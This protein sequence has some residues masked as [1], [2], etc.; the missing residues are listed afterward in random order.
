MELIAK[1]PKVDE[2]FETIRRFLIVQMHSV[3]VDK[4]R[5]AQTLTDVRRKLSKVQRKAIADVISSKEH[6]NVDIGHDIMGVMY[7]PSPEH[8]LPRI[9]AI[10]EVF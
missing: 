7:D 4:M 9:K 1:K 5:I 10:Q 6:R 8:F 2:D 3:G